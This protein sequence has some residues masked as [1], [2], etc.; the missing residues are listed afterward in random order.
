MINFTYHN[1]VKIVFGKG[2]IPEL[3]DLVPSGHKVML[4]Y[5]G[6]SIKQNGVYDQIRNALSEFDVTEFSGIEPNPRYE[7]CMR[8]AAQAKE[9]KAQF[10]L[11]AGGGSV[12]DAAKFI[13]V[14]ALYDEAVDPWEIMEHRKPVAAALPIGM[15]VTLPGT[16]S[17]MNSFSVISRESS[18]EKLAFGSPHCYPKFSILDPETTFSIPMRQVENGIVDTFAHVME[19]YMCAA[20]SAPLTERQAE[21]L[22]LTVIEQAPKLLAN[23]KD[24]ELRANLMW[25]ATI[26]LNGSLGCGVETEDWSSHMLGH[27]L[28][29]RY[30]LDHA[31]SLAVMMPAV[32]RHQLKRKLPRLVQCAAR[33]WNISAINDL[34]RADKAVDRM[35]EFFR[36]T[37]MST[38]LYEY[39]IDANEAAD[40]TVERLSKRGVML[41]E[42]GDLGPKEI[43]EIFMLAK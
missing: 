28:T 39:K 34:V 19:Q 7:T 41:G 9:Q 21:A 27:E 23:P 29:A 13:A 15:V 10:L 25:C 6:G 3:K 30:G 16:G 24:Y 31:R 8:A 26:A 33:V 42:N 36:Q 17:E 11:A 43:R 40:I 18:G 2:T 32:H 20:G 37:G 22:L 14:A 5:G 38:R 35:E 4:L 12:M 1:P